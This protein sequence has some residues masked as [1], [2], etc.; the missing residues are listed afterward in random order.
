[1]SHAGV[2]FIIY[3]FTKTIQ[4]IEYQKEYQDG[5]DTLAARSF[6]GKPAPTGSLATTGFRD[7]HRQDRG[8]NLPDGCGNPAFI[9]TDT[10]FLLNTVSD[11]LT[12]E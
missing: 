8:T 11:Q 3:F 6:Q 5:S 12:I 7:R 1:M 4:G 2:A 10:P 9:V